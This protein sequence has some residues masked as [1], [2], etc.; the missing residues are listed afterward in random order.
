M[1]RG[2]INDI[3]NVLPEPETPSKPITG[4]AGTMFVFTSDVYHGASVVQPGLTRRTM[5]GHTHRRAMLQ[6][7]GVAGR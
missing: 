4:P 7:M 5:R 3:P 2:T 6:A 1:A